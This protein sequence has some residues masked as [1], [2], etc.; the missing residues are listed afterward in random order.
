M[1]NKI[2]PEILR[3]NKEQYY[4]NGDI[5]LARAIIINN[6]DKFRQDRKD[7]KQ[8]DIEFINLYNSGKIRPDLHKYIE[9]LSVHRLYNWRRDLKDNTYKNVENWAA[10]LPA[11]Y[12]NNYVSF[13]WNRQECWINIEILE[14]ISGYSEKTLRNRCYEGRYIRKSYITEDNQYIEKVLIQSLDDEIKRKIHY[15]CIKS[16]KNLIDTIEQIQDESS[17]L[18]IVFKELLKSEEFSKW[19]KNNLPRLQEVK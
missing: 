19:V 2:S 15:F 14:K 17:C 1:I 4:N 3:N 10:L 9:A 12:F 6:W 13:L 11:G 8:A 16:F 7:L 5:A 18:N